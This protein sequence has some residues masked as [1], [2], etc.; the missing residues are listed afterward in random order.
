MSQRQLTRD[1]AVALYES[2][3]WKTWPA[4]ELAVFQLQQDRLCVPFDAF[5]GAVEKL[6]GRPVY[7]HEFGLNRA[8]LLAEAQR[9]VGQTGDKP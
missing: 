3:K 1:E 2:G 9:A 6:L 4:A 7:T 5:H 8:G